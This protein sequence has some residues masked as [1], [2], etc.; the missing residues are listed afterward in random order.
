VQW[1]YSQDGLSAQD[2][3]LDPSDNLIIGGADFIQKR[4]PAGLPLWTLEL[5]CE[6]ECCVATDDL[7]NILVASLGLLRKLDPGGAEIWSADH[8]AQAQ[9]VAV[10]VDGS[11]LVA[12]FIEV[13]D[14]PHD[15]WVR[16]YDPDGGELWTV[17]HDGGGTSHD[18]AS[19]VATDSAGNVIVAGGESVVGESGRRR[20][21]A[22][23][24]S[25]GSLVW[26]DSIDE[27]VGNLQ[28]LRSVAVDSQ[29]NIV[30]TGRGESTCG[31]ENILVRKHDPDGE[32]LWSRMEDGD[33]HGDDR[34]NDVA[35]DAS[36]NVIVVGWV[37]THHVHRNDD[38]WLRKYTPEGDVVW[39]VHRRR[40][41]C[42]GQGGGGRRGRK[43]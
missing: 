36:D 22:K 13:A 12:G 3:A 39:T 8:P 31:G 27:P 1:G 43:R 11:I 5:S 28:G 29:N 26:Q 24:D 20:W 25:E 41:R 18:T 32:E 30:V 35:T 9:A 42:R 6:G 40:R 33:M 10:A 16:K 38:I 4:D 2:L 19:D 17:T 7:G 14:E 23:Y 37:D 34:G 15:A 21:L